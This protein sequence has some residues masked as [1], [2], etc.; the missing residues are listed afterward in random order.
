MRRQL[1]AEGAARVGSARVARNCLWIICLT[2]HQML[3]KALL[4]RRVF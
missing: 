1:Y 2:P 3:E 4:A